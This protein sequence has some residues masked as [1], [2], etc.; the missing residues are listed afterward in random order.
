MS[1]KESRQTSRA[2]G[3]W[4]KAVDAMSHPAPTSTSSSTVP[5]TPIPQPS[6]KTVQANGGDHSSSPAGSVRSSRSSKSSKKSVKLGQT[7]PY[8][9]RHNRT[10]S[11]ISYVSINAPTRRPPIL[12]EDRTEELNETDG[13]LWA[14]GVTI[15]QSHVVSGSAI[16]AGAY[17]V[18]HC[19]VQ[20]LQVSSSCTTTLAQQTTTPDCQ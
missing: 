14:R 2:S 20:T 8:W 6:N 4:L 13:A 19:T 18:W 7:P 10:N 9:N 16:G 17:V 11:T 15:D 12:L 3:P 5:P 1:E